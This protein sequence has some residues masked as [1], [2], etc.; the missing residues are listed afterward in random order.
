MK[1][2]NPHCAILRHSGADGGVDRVWLSRANIIMIAII[3]A[4]TMITCGTSA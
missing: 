1:D 3:I 4:I 2:A